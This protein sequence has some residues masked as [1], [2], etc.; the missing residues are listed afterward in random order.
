M[1]QI[2]NILHFR[3]VQGLSSRAIAKSLGCGKTVVNNCIKKAAQA[4][5]SDWESVQ[6]LSEVELEQKLYPIRVTPRDPEGSYDEP[7]WVQVE[8][9]M[10]NKDVT[11]SLLW[12]EYTEKTGQKVYKYSRFCDLYRNWKKK[13]SVVMR[14]DHRAGEKAF[15]DYCDGIC[16]TN[17]ETGEQIKTQLFVGTLGASSYTFVEATYSQKQQDWLSSHTRMFEFFKGVTPITVCDN[18]RSGVTQAC[19]YEPVINRSYQDLAD[20]YGTCIIPAHPYKPRHKAKAE[21]AVLVAQRWILAVLRHETF[22][23]LAEMSAAIRKLNVRLNE[24]VMRR[25][26]KSR[27]ELY[28][29]IDLPA[30][31]PLP[32]TPY[33]FSEWIRC[34]LGMDY[35]VV[36]DDHHYSAPYVLFKKELWVRSTEKVVEIF[37]KGERVA[38]HLRSFIK[39]KHTSL[40]EHMP[41]THR[42]YAE[43]TP[44][45]IIR[46]AYSIGE[47]TRSVTERIMEKKE[48]PEQGFKACMG[49]LSLAKSYGSDRLEKACTRALRLSTVN[50]RSIKV[51]LQNKMESSEPL[52]EEQTL[53]QPAPQA[54]NSPTSE[55]IRGGS[56]YH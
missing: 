34:K 48:H 15:V 36:I 22:Y 8:L 4:S 38:S 3:Y 16:I 7:D 52:N 6:N 20:H 25:I 26:K 32:V 2:K 39:W 40:P 17:R 1:R 53:D 30:L 51:I 50:Y 29:A 49:I 35:H 10:K 55:N 9:E 46:W 23:S 13:L 11:L 18:L 43:W 47:S 21:V 41:S 33:E 19:K 56:Y 54:P 31:L 28:E 14:H 42:A 45:R 12:Q 37:Y 5:L 27:R 44:E 24:R